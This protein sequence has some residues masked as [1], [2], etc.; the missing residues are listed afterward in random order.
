MSYDTD[1]LFA[2]VIGS[3]EN[4]D[5]GKNA[6]KYIT[7]APIPRQ[8]SRK[9]TEEPLSNGRIEAE[10]I[11][12]E[13]IEAE[14]IESER[15]ETER[16]ETER[17]EAERIET[18]RAEAERAEAERIETERI[19]TERAE[20]E[21]IETER[22]EAERAEKKRIAEATAEKE[23]IDYLKQQELDR[24]ALKNQRESDAKAQQEQ[25]EIQKIEKERNTGEFTIST[26]ELVL[27]VYNLLTSYQDTELDSVRKFVNETDENA[28]ILKILNEKI[29]TRKALVALVKAQEAE[30]VDRAFFLVA[31]D[32]KLLHD[33]GSIMK[34]YDDSELDLSK[35]NSSRIEYCR[36][37]EFAI[38]NLTVDMKHKLNLIQQL[39]I[40]PISK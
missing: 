4:K 21:R 20:A 13:R 24:I 26:V 5:E 6:V 18:E 28:I 39:F 38:N 14:R 40:I 11:E 12:S 35:I 9:E 27:S 32:N 34:T 23:R 15:I 16:I 8:I 2:D 22:A 29:E 25:E 7:A 33:M 31:L 30:Q 1:D 37:L 36:D 19:E 3:V 10:R 17:I